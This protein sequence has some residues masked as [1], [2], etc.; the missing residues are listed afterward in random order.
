MAGVEQHISQRHDQPAI[1]LGGGQTEDLIFQ[2]APLLL[3]TGQLGLTQRQLQTLALHVHFRQALLAQHQIAVLTRDLA[4]AAAEVGVVSDIGTAPQVTGQTLGASQRFASANHILGRA[5]QHIGIFLDLLE[6]G[7][8]L[9]QGLPAVLMT[10]TP[11][12]ASR[13]QQQAH[14]QYTRKTVHCASPS[15]LRNRLRRVFN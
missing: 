4:V 6:I 15:C 2:P 14:T 10:G 5:A 13:T 9:L 3:G 7:T 12:K 11:V 8:G 1:G